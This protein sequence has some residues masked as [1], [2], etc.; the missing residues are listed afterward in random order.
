MK[1]GGIVLKNV[2]LYFS[3]LKGSQAKKLFGIDSN[4]LVVLNCEESSNQEDL[5]SDVG[6]VVSIFCN[7]EELLKESIKKVPLIIAGIRGNHDNYAKK[8]AEIINDQFGVKPLT[9][10]IVS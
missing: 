3:K 10:H 1:I 5:N 6:F 8:L 7:G 9:L 2:K 4:N